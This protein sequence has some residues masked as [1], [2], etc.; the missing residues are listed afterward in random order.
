MAMKDNALITCERFDQFKNVD[1]KTFS[2]PK[3]DVRIVRRTTSR[4]R[5]SQM[6]RRLVFKVLN[7]F[8]PLICNILQIKERKTNLDVIDAEIN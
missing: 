2:P 1:S 4:I 6:P 7:K 3:E 8:N 5:A